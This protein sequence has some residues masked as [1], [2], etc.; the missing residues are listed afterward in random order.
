MLELAT[1]TTLGAYVIAD[2]IGRGGM[3]VVYRAHHPA[4]ERDV[5]IKVLWQSLADQPGFLERFRREARAASSVRHPN[6][7]TIYDFGTQGG[8][9]Y[10]VSE[11]L[12]G[13]SLAE[14]LHGPARLDET[15]QVIR[16]IGAALDVAHAAGLIHRDV[17]PSNILFTGDGQPVLA[18]FGIARMLQGEQ[19][20]ITVQGSLIGTPHYLAPEMASGAESVGPASDLYSLG[21]VLY[22]MLTGGPPFPRETPIATVRAHIVEA[23]P[24]VRLRNP[25]V[26]PEVE[27]VV[28]R[29]LAK[30]PEGRFPSG[31]A[32]AAAFEHAL[33][34]AERPTPPAGTPVPVGAV[35][36]LRGQT[37]PIAPA[38]ATVPGLARRYRDRGQLAPR[39]GRR[40]SMLPLLVLIAACLVVAAGV[41][42]WRTAGFSTQITVAPTRIAEG[43]TPGGAV[44]PPTPPPTLAGGGPAA[45][46]STGTTTVPVAIGSPSPGLPTPSPSPIVVVFPSHTPRPAASPTT[47]V[48]PTATPDPKRGPLSVVFL[49]PANGEAVPARPII[50]G[51]R[52]GLQGP[53]D[54]LW[55]LLH[56]R[57]G[58]ENWWP[59]KHE[60]IADRDGRWQVDDLEI[61]GPPGS[62]HD[63]AVGVV[64][65]Q[66]NQVILDQISQHTDDPFV[67]GQPPGFRELARVTVVKR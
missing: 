31:A 66:G 36:P 45:S 67:G 12:T 3:A 55:L 21:V 32:L 40:R 22:E 39:Q 8:I 14:R 50:S 16:G 63:L 30:R 44:T 15:L 34:S 28:A 17:K 49:T 2:S 42:A 33:D 59:L 41:Y 6:I 37:Q 61:G 53:D 5:A 25:E 60:L 1:G 48:L 52:T 56:P 64:D 26:P 20:Q 13:G 35:V 4:L 43:A 46:P 38:S 24:P 47:V 29:A 65:A 7:L 10:M 18:D 19:H 9:T 23:P 57:G 54:H 58:P 62:E 27:A 11:L 51:Q